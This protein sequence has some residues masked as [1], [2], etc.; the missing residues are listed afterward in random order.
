[1]V[2]D[3]DE[4]PAERAS[5]RHHLAEG[6]GSVAVGRV[7]LEVGVRR[8]LPVG[9]RVEHRP[10]LREREVPG[11]RLVGLREDRRG[12]EPALDPLGHP[13]TDRRELGE[14]PPG[15]GQIR[16]LLAPEPGGARGTPEC[17]SAMRVLLLAGAPQEVG[18]VAVRQARVAH[19][20]TVVQTAV[21]TSPARAA[22]H[23]SMVSRRRRTIAIVPLVILA[24]L[25]VAGTSRHG[26]PRSA[27]RGPARSSALP[28]PTSCAALRATTRSSV[29]A[30]TT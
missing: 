19:R 13:G 16:R 5:G 7:D 1:M 29:S 22:E 28:A 10:D 3:R 2:G 12:V 23:P 20:P 21:L 26:P 11:S 30:G 8:P 4:G 6:E 14:R 24:A 17:A 9:I 27:S 25:V 15:R 18:Q